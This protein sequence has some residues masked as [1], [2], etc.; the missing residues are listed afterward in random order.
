MADLKHESLNVYMRRFDAEASSFERVA[1]Y[2]L[3]TIIQQ[4][5]ASAFDEADKGR[6]SAYQLLRAYLHGATI[7]AP[8][9][10]KIE[11]QELWAIAAWLEFTRL[12]KRKS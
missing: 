6:E 9:Q 4:W 8:L 7:V 5:W 11:L 1:D 12:S 3:S 2:E 10:L